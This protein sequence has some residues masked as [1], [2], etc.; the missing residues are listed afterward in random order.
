MESVFWADVAA[1]VLIKFGVV[2]VVVLA[3]AIWAAVVTVTGVVVVELVIEVGA[4]DVQAAFRK[5]AH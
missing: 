3:C 1:G 5:H 2:G 4:R